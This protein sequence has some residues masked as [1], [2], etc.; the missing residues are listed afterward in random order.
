MHV[1]IYLTLVRKETE[2]APR[3]RLFHPCPM[4]CARIPAQVH[5]VGIALGWPARWFASCP[6]SLFVGTV[7]RQH[8]QGTPKLSRARLSIAKPCT[9]PVG[10]IFIGLLSDDAGS[11]HK[12]TPTPRPRMQGP[13]RKCGMSDSGNGGIWGISYLRS[14]ETMASGGWCRLEGKGKKK[15]G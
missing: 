7:W 14:S 3:R 13:M 6:Q 5:S 4:R 10:C 12:T 15:G 8:A 1:H 9:P 11:D 2:W